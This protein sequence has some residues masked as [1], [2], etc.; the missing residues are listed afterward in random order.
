MRISLI[1]MKLI[2]PAWI[3]AVYLALAWC[4]ALPSQPPQNAPVDRTILPLQ[5]PA[6]PPV[7]EIDVRNA[8][9]PARFE[10]RAAATGLGQCPNG[11]PG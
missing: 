9:P 2:F 4:Q 5:E 6:R 7:T 11:I 1:T 8:V 3:A 10:V